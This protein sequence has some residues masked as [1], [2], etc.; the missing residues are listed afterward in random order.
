MSELRDNAELERYEIGAGAVAY[1][2]RHG[3]AADVLV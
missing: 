3:D 2:A 1:L